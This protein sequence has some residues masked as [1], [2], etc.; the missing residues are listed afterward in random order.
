[1]CIKQIKTTNHNSW[2]IAALVLV[3]STPLIAAA[4]PYTPVTRLLS[5]SS[6]KYTT[7][8]CRSNSAYK[9]TIERLRDAQKGRLPAG[10][11]KPLADCLI[12]AGKKKARPIIYATKKVKKKTIREYRQH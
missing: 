5:A 8:A 11:F 12:A 4:G 1:M 7:P 2:V 6:P 9:K 10:N 3:L